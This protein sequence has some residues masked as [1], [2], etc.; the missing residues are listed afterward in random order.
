MQMKRWREVTRRVLWGGRED[1]LTQTKTVLMWLG[2][3][4]RT[5]E[6][7]STVRES[8]KNIGHRGIKMKHSKVMHGTLNLVLADR[9]CCAIHLSHPFSILLIRSQT[10]ISPSWKI[11]FRHIKYMSREVQNEN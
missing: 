5:A 1:L 7:M 6:P 3:C 9:E 4:E 10:A 11:I 8:R 2:S